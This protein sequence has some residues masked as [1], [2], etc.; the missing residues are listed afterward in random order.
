MEPTFPLIGLAGEYQRLKTAVLKRQPLLILGPGGSGK[1]K[2]IA[3]VL[4]TLPAPH[5]IVSIQYSSNLHHLLIDLAR[6]LL[7]A[8]HATFRK[9]ARPGSDAEKWLSQQTSIHLK[10]L[11]WTALEAEPRVIVLDG[12]AGAGFPTYRFLQRLY[13]VKDMALLASARD[14]VSLGTLG[15][16]FWDPRNT[17]HLHP[18]HTVDANHLFDLAVA[19]FEL[20]H[21]DVEEFRGKVLEAAKGNPGQLIEMC[22]LA[23]DPMY[24]SG[25]H[26]KFAPLRIDVLMKFL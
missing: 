13:S 19:R 16:L 4:A 7:R 15:R 18:L 17:I 22:K 14:P 23:S 11:L 6:A 24:I 9:L 25:T 26:I 10:G 20:S 21:L 2:L 8:G 3:A 12:I 1:S 5:E